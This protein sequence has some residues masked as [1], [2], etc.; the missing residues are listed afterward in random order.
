MV[1]IYITVLLQKLG[2]GT[3]KRHSLL[4][5]HAAVKSDLFHLSE[6]SIYFAINEVRTY[7]VF[8]GLVREAR[9]NFFSSS[10][11]VMYTR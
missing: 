10:E 9:V 7:G 5:S 8:F 6:I 1:W 3:T 11:E 4:L 2:T